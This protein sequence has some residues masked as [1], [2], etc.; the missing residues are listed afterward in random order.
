MEVMGVSFC[1]IDEIIELVGCDLFM[2]LFKLLDQLWES[3][4]VLIQKLDVV[5]FIDGEV[6]IYV[7]CVKF[8]VLMQDDWMVIDKFMEGI[9]GFS[10]V[11]EIL[12]Y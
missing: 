3:D 7:D 10:K 2:I 4:V 11:I 8:D 9:K 5:N 6:K 12:E 1:N